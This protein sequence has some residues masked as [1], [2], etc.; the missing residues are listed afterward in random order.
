MHSEKQLHQLEQSIRVLGWT[1]PILIDADNKVL[2]GHGRLLAA[3]RL[4]I[5]N[6]PVIRIEDMT[7]A[8]KRA[9]ILAD[10]RLA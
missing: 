7:E 5:D 4:G 2:A 6:V 9:Y 10:N 1:N 3:K 8:Q